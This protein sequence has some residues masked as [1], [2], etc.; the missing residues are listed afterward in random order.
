MD[1]KS[2]IF[3]LVL[4]LLIAGSVG[5]AYWRIVVRKDYVVQTQ[6]DCDPSVEKCF[7]WECDP[8]S[9]EEGEA[10]TGDS[11]E[12]VWYYQLQ[13]RNASN[14]PLCNPE[15]DEDCQPMSCNSY[16]EK[17]CET[18]YCDEKTAIEQETECNDPEEYL[19]NNPPEEEEDLPVDEDSSSLDETVLPAD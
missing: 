19:L 5:M 1:K 3:F 13:K 18:V 15:E 2:K 12:D 10:C 8:E 4:F 9:M 16:I 14:V 7:I 11:E 6:E 17:D